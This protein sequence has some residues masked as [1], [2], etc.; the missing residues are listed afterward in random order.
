[1]DAAASLIAVD[2]EQ[3]LLGAIL[4]D[5]DVLDRIDGELVGDDF[6]D[7]INRQLYDSFTAAHQA[8]DH[9][10]VRLAVAMLGEDAKTQI[11]SELT[12]GQYVARLCAEAVGIRSAKSY[13][14]KLRDLADKRRSSRSPTGS[15]SPSRD[16]VP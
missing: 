3:A 2:L 11:T 8:G 10:D 12:V 6:G 1:M 16:R 7:P 15:R 5:P 4:H 14:R 9:I 13:A